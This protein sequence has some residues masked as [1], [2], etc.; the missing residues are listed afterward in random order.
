MGILDGLMQAPQ[1]GVP[2]SGIDFSAFTQPQAAPMAPQ[3]PV[4]PPQSA[5][6]QQQTYPGLKRPPPAIGT[7]INGQTY[8]GGDPRDAAGSWKQ[9]TG[10]TY[11][12]SLPI[13]EEKKALIKMMASY[14]APASGARGIGSPEVQQLVGMAKL[15]D[16]AFDI[17][18]YTVRQNYLHDLNDQKANGTIQALNNAAMHAKSFDDEFQKLDNSNWLPQWANRGLDYIGRSATQT[19]AGNA[20]ES[21]TVLGP[22]ISR[23]AQ[24]GQPTVDEVNR[25]IGNLDI[26]ARPNIEKGTMSSMASKIGDRMLSMQ[27]QYRRAFGDIAPK[28]PL[29]TPQAALAAHQLLQRYAPDYENKLDFGM[30]TA[31]GYSPQQ[32]T[33]MQTPAAT[34][35]TTPA[36]DSLLTKYGPKNGR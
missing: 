16:P 29:M 18:Q 12:N 14:D 8:I 27:A 32:A 11:L 13:D 22:E 21:Q 4:Q 33:A 34:V 28:E 17:K 24:G 10:D 26:G 6:P 9:A 3:P 2:S 30:L 35:P 31:G 5:T 1:I 19:A 36:I 25:Q 23:V 15:Y 7:T 20:A